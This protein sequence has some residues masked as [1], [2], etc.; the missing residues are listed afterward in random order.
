MIEN[1]NKSENESENENKSEKV[2]MRI[3]VK[4]KVKMSENEPSRP[5]GGGPPDQC[6]QVG[7]DHDVAN[8][9]VGNLPQPHLVITAVAG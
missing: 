7:H 3:K 1:K 6:Q 8:A 5:E 9:R 2:K 4:I